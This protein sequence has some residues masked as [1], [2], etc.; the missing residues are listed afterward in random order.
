LSFDEARFESGFERGVRHRALGG[1]L[2]AGDAKVGR[3]DGVGG[4]NQGPLRLRPA[5]C[6]A[7][8]RF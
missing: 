1:T 6:A 2:P 3:M 7:S 4:R 8:D 5:V